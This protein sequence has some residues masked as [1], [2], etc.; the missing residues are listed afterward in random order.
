MQ[1]I[2]PTSLLKIGPENV[3]RAVKMF[4]G[5]QKFMDDGTAIADRTASPAKSQR[6]ELVQKL[7]HQVERVPE[8]AACPCQSQIIVWE[9]S[10]LLLE[11]HIIG[12]RASMH[13][14]WVIG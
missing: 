4:A 3:S 6:L 7:L 13:Y 11:G 2:I 8:G 1:E 14:C 10:V 12:D 9:R 5:V